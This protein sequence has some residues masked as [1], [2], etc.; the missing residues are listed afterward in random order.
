MHIYVFGVCTFVHT[1]AKRRTKLPEPVHPVQPTILFNP[2][3]ASDLSPSEDEE[4]E[5]DGYWIRNSSH[6]R[7]FRVTAE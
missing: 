3:A 1:K 5:E 6:Q 2:M 4:P 7:S